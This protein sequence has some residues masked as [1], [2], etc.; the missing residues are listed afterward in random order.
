MQP[1]I[2]S[3]PGYS[4]E[5]RRKLVEERLRGSKSVAALCRE[6]NVGEVA[7]RRWHWYS[8]SLSLSPSGSGE[9]SESMGR[10]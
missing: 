4:P 10:G 2:M 9:G 1:K 5:F 7:F 3:K 6:Y 8:R